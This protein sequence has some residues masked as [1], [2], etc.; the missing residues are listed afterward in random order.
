MNSIV[1]DPADK[2]TAEKVE[3]DLEEKMKTFDISRLSLADFKAIPKSVAKSP[4]PFDGY[5]IKPKVQI[6]SERKMVSVQKKVPKQ[7]PMLDDND[8]PVLYKGGE[9]AGQLRTK[10]EYDAVTVNEMQDVPIM[11][12]ATYILALAPTVHVHQDPSGKRIS[13]FVAGKERFVDIPSLH[14]RCV[15]D[16]EGGGNNTEIVFDRE[17]ELEGGAKITIALCPSHSARAQIMFKLDE[18][19]HKIDV[20]DR[21]LLLDK[22][23]EK[24]LR[25]IFE[26][27]H[28]PKIRT[29]RLA[30]AIMGESDELLEEVPAT[31]LEQ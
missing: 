4:H 10:T 24:P 9:K 20:D 8:K 19:T 14:S 1:K 31:A 25:R 6:G 15:V 11:F 22:P 3:K 29:E 26:M 5:P 21:Y 12:S 17:L 28:N 7:V 23:Q 13:Q 27:I 18:R 30:A 16:H 2:A